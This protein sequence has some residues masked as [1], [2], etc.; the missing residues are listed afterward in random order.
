MIRATRVTMAPDG[1]SVAHAPA[2][3]VM[4]GFGR[5]VIA[6]DNDRYFAFGLDSIEG[7]HA[8]DSQCRG[9]QMKQLFS[10]CAIQFRNGSARDPINIFFARDGVKY[11]KLVEAG[12]RLFNMAGQRQLHKNGVDGGFVAETADLVAQRQSADVGIQ[13]MQLGMHAHVPA[14]FHFLS[15]ITLRGRAITHKH[16]VQAGDDVVASSQFLYL[17]PDGL[18]N[19]VGN[20]LAVH[21]LCHVHRL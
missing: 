12:G 19:L 17:G 13:V 4:N 2:E 9:R 7:N 20:R 21:Y 1:G 18:L 16:Y 6:A 10:L 5:N 14:R 15:D 11:V 8:T 3:H